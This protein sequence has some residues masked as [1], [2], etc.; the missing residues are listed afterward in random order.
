MTFKRTQKIA[1]F[2]MIIIY[3]IF[4]ARSPVF[5]STF[6]T[7]IS[8]NSGTTN[9]LNGVWGVTS[10]D[11]FVVGKSGTIG[12]FDG[13]KWSLMASGIS[14]D[15][16]C[17]WG[18]SS[19]NVFTAG[20]SGTTGFFDGTKWSLMDSGTTADLN[21][22]F[23]VTST[24][25]VAVGN[26]GAI[27]RYDGSKWSLMDSGTTV[28]LNSI[29]GSV[30]TDMFV[31]GKSG[32]IG[33]FDGSKWSLM[34]SGT[35]NDL[36]SVWGI[37]SNDVFAVGKSGTVLHYDGSKWSAMNSVIT[38]DLNS[39]W[40][41]AG[42][43]IFVVGKSGTIG[44]FDGSKW[45]SMNS[46]TLNE[47]RGIKGFSPSDVIV[48]GWSGTILRYLPPLVKSISINEGEQGTRLDVTIIGTNLTGTSDVS[49]GTGIAVNSFNVLNSQQLITNIT[50][51]AGA[52]VGTRD[53][54]VTTP[55]GGFTFPNSFTVRLALP[56]ITSI[57]PDQDTQATTPKVTITGTN[58]TG[59]SEVR[60]GA[61]VAVNSFSVL[62]TN[63]ISVNIS[64]AADATPG[65]RGISVTTPAGSFT[66]PGGFTVR[67]ALPTIASVNPSQGNRETT[68]DIIIAGTNLTGAGEVQ[69][70]TGI[71]VNSFSILSS[72]QIKANISLA[73]DA[74]IRARNVSITTPG[75]S[76]TLP[77]AFM[78]KPALP[79]ITSI[80]PDNGSQGATLSV[81]IRG[82]NLTE[83]G[84]VRFSTGTAVNSFTVVSSSQITANIT[85]VGGAE[86][87]AG[88]VSVTTPGGNFSLPNSF[89]VKQ[90]LPVITSISPNHGSKGATLDVIISGS[91]FDRT[92]SVSL[93]TGV[94]VKSFTNLS[95]IQLR[96][97]VI[98]DTKAVTG[99]RD[100]S[101]TTL[102]GSSTSGN[103][104]TIEKKS[105]GTGILA[106]I[107]VGIVIVVVL[108]IYILNLLRKNIDRDTRER[109]SWRLMIQ[110]SD[111][112]FECTTSATAD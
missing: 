3:F 86:I 57:V 100:V 73:T 60:L 78:V 34:S 85:I 64:I 24:S 84:E 15:L 65:A 33:H 22:V 106:L 17:V 13:T 82:T 1:S 72:N 83:T 103:S 52:A 25:V 63:Q 28:D 48:T 46:G 66:L 20:K 62:S 56:T 32:T 9:D 7:W 5:A 87:G 112:M 55:G 8:M 80:T 29:W 27:S 67:Q 47:L 39:V 68:F 79:T 2:L 21:S 50:I 53:V 90:G 45:S 54:S 49:F 74:E 111:L 44:H 23:G 58:L 42:T 99:V 81:T 11:A 19:N 96:V 107:W 35:T 51:V 76:V 94:T 41:S 12:R 18:S 6:T 30:S 16:N 14:N 108:F 37:A 43:D 69:I 31:V 40:G 93:G 36:N 4:L 95:P 92:T 102:G 101:V 70:G 38:G 88:N 26:S 77:N 61:G 97:N 109:N 110:V 59:A 10:A 91:N 105:L 104:F 75:G 89:T 98:I 71:T